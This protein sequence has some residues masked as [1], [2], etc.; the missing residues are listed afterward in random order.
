MLDLDGLNIWSNQQLVGYLWRNT[1]GLIGFR[2]ADEW[3]TQGGY[4]ISQTLPLQYEDFA[5]E[6]D[7]AHR[8]FANLLPEGSVRDRI[9]R[10]LKIANTDFDLLRTIG[11]ECAGALSI[12]QAE[13][14]PFY[15]TR[16][17]SSFGR[18]TRQPGHSSESGLYMVQ[19]GAPTTVFGRCPGQMPGIARK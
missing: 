8:F 4:A 7:V 19:H 18:G 11:G 12:L 2:Y 14:Q 13:H 6:T 16:L 3:L 1:Q 10:S 15:G 9:V 5:P 17:P